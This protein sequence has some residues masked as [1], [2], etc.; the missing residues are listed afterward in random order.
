M[1]LKKFFSQILLSC[2]INHEC[3]EFSFLLKAILTRSLF[4]EFTQLTSL[5]SVI[6]IFSLG[7]PLSPFSSAG[8]SYRLRRVMEVMKVPTAHRSLE[9]D[10]TRVNTWGRHAKADIGIIPAF[11]SSFKVENNGL[12]CYCIFIRCKIRSNLKLKIIRIADSTALR[13]KFDG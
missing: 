2:A 5:L 3:S 7:L 11:L 1:S 4:I 8:L 10:R 9:A 6:T 13:S 12:N